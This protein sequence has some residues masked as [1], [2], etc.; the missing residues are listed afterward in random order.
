MRKSEQHK[1]EQHLLVGAV[2]A[3]VLGACFGG[4]FLDAFHHPR[5]HRLPVAAVA[6][7]PLVRQLQSGLEAHLPGAFRIERYST[8]A[9]ARRAIADRAVDGAFIVRSQGAHLLVASAAGMA[10]A[11]ILTQA[12]TNEATASG[13]RLTVTDVTRLPAQNSE[14]LSIFFLVISLLLPSLVVAVVS[15]LAPGDISAPVQAGVLAVF[16]VVIA[17]TT[18]WIADELTGA[19]PGHYLPLT[20]TAALFSLS[21]SAPTAALARLIPPGAALAGLIFLIIG[22]PATGGPVGLAQFLPAFFRAFT[23]VLPSSVTIPVLTN[24]TYFDGHAI[25]QDLWVLAAWAVGGLLALLATSRLRTRG[26]AARRA[27]ASDSRAVEP[28]VAT[29]SS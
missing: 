14:G 19:L 16:A 22:V 11:Q 12:F 29:Q 13:Q 2:A 24:I 26:P 1:S 25:A 6:P 4:S 8:A 28:G 20:G 7:A 27:A 10:P 15:S 23:P 17:A 21:I 3:L 5:P 18:V 9:A